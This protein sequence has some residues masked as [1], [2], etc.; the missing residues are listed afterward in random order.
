[1]KSEKSKMEQVVFISSRVKEMEK[2]RKAVVKAVSELGTQESLPLKDWT[3][4]SAKEIPSGKDSDEVQTEGIT[5]SDIYVLILGSEYGDFEYGESP[6]HKE[7]K[8]ACSQIERDC[9]LIFYAEVEDREEKLDRWLSE[10]KGKHT[11]KPF[12]NED[13]LLNLVKNRLRDI[14]NKRCVN[15]EVII[16]KALH[17][18]QLY[19]RSSKSECYG[20][21]F[22]ANKL[23][24]EIKGDDNSK[25][26][27]AFFISLLIHN[28]TDYNTT[29]DNI[30]LTVCVKDK[31]MITLD[32]IKFENDKWKD[33][34][35]DEF[36]CIIEK[37]SSKRL[38]FRFISR[39]F[40]V[41]PEVSIKLTLNHTFGNFKVSGCSEFI[42]KIDDIEWTKGSSRGSCA[43]TDQF[44][45]SST[46]IPSLGKTDGIPKM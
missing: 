15:I 4:E 37:Q 5:R 8:T 1:M 12:K 45:Y 10:L 19:S 23:N 3:W 26:F 33:Y 6:T 40:L 44:P 11:Y 17:V 32:R 39:D 21:S 7:Y 36:T 30:N 38:F 42:E 35:C 9:I 34:D 29:I 46:S 25:S 20:E 16:K 18:P 24:I 22:D 31:N 28:K 14:C 13:D 43:L 2:E 41:E 27:I